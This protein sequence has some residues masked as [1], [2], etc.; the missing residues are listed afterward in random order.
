[1]NSGESETVRIA[2]PKFFVLSVLFSAVA[3]YSQV[4]QSVTGGGS[5]LWAGGEYANFN[6]DYGGSRLSGIGA[7]VDFNLTHKFGAVG[8]ARW[9]RWSGGGDLG[10]TQNDYL[11]GA[12]YRVFQ[13]SRFSVAAKFLVGGVWIKFPIG[14]G[15]GSY[16]AYAPGGIVDYRLSPHFLVRGGYEYQLLPSA[17]DIPNQPNNG[18]TPNGFTAGIEYRI[19]R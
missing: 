18:L 2:I 7:L 6:P 1:L 14:R 8:E 13:H 3:A 4:A 5:S 12:K 10:E 17:P 19:L 16:F 9:L 11:A 15:S